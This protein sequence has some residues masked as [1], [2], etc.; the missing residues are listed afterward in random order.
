VTVDRRPRELTSDERNTLLSVVREIGLV[1]TRRR[2]GIASWTLDKLI[3]QVDGKPIYRVRPSIV[4]RVRA[5]LAGGHQAQVTRR[6]RELHPVPMCG[7]RVMRFVFEGDEYTC[8]ADQA[9]TVSEW[10]AE[11]GVAVASLPMP[12][13]ESWPPRWPSNRWTAA[14]RDLCITHSREENARRTTRR[15]ALLKMRAEA[16]R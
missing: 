6:R 1:A 4:Q 5:L 12:D 3:V 10:I 8:S 16:Q 13:E 9:P 2:F 11:H 14:A 15:A 7:D